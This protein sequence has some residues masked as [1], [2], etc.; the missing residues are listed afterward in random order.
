MADTLP[1]LFCELDQKVSLGELTGALKN[2]NLNS[3]MFQL[4]S[5]SVLANFIASFKALSSTKL[6]ASF[7]I[8]FPNRFLHIRVSDSKAMLCLAMIAVL[9]K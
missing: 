2:N 5:T 1:T 3:K 7:R 4:A 9:L 8:Y 6:S